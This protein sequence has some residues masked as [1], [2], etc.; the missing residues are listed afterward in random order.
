MIVNINLSTI[1]PIGIMILIA[2]SFSFVYLLY[3]K[4]YI[5]D[6]QTGNADIE[7]IDEFIHDNLSRVK[8]RKK[9]IKT[10]N[11]FAFYGFLIVMTPIFIFSI[12][13]K[14]SGS[15]SNFGDFGLL[16]VSSGSMSFKNP[17][18]N[19]LVER[20]LNN[21]FNTYDLIVVEMIED[22]EELNVDDVIV[23]LDATGKLTIHRIVAI[24]ENELGVRSYS[25]RGDAN[26]TDDT[27][28]STFK[29]IKGKYID[30]RIPFV[31][32]FV[33]FFQSLMGIITIVILIGCILIF[34]NQNNKI[35]NEKQTRLEKFKDVNILE[36]I[37]SSTTDVILYYKGYK[38]S[39]NEKGYIIKDEI[40]TSNEYYE[41]SINSVI[42]ICADTE[43]LVTEY[44]IDE[45]E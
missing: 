9:T 7:L 12:A 24:N 35:L 41:K 29:D 31:G 15:I 1:I 6:I 10:I 20:N 33:L 18:N 22:E 16:A 32:A 39:F 28:I 27:F 30:T 38:Y 8:R 44:I 13:N 11:T 14:L 43:P 19:Y 26:N 5:K 42:K 21:Q 3:V 17:V 4:Y 37:N 25:T 36:F 45:R 23:F 34:D 40:A 2:I